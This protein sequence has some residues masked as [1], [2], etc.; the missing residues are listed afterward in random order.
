MSD[1]DYAKRMNNKWGSEIGEL[2][3]RYAIGKNNNDWEPFNSYVKTMRSKAKWKK[4]TDEDRRY[5]RSR[6]K[7]SIGGKK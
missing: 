1:Q 5:I 4:A 3:M 7:M 2:S 6:F